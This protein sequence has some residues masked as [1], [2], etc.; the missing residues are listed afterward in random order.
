MNLRNEEGKAISVL[1]VNCLSGE[2]Q[3]NEALKL[4]S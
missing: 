1:N 2:E 3:Q 4:L